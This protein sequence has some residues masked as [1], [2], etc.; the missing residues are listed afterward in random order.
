MLK[1]RCARRLTVGL[2]VLGLTLSSALS[3]QGATSRDSAG[4]Q[5]SSVDQSALGALPEWQVT[6]PLVNIGDANGPE[7]YEFH[8]AARPLRLSDGRIVVANDGTELRVYSAAGTFLTRLSRAGAGPGEYRNIQGLTRIAG[9]TLRLHDPSL[10][11]MD[12][13]APSGVV[14]R[15]EAGVRATALW[16]GTGKGMYFASEVPGTSYGRGVVQLRALLV[17]V[18]QSGLLQDTVAFLP[19]AWVNVVEPGHWLSVGLANDP[20][21]VAGAEHFAYAHG[22]LLE[23]RWFD[24]SGVIRAISRIASERTRVTASTIERFRRREAAREASANLLR[25]EPVPKVAPA[26]AEYLPQVSRLRLDSRDRAWICRADR[27][28]EP[29][30]DWVVLA[31]GGAPLARVRMPERFVP[32]DIG[33][34]YILGIATDEDGVQFVRMYGLL[35]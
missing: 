35:R 28:G 10:R 5:I 13:R 34:D 17:M 19:G 32:S 21:F 9:D 23:V 26:F 11:R 31:T 2:A 33:D 14:A 25:R 27:F 6:G 15:S 20:F 4:I 18:S 1:Q 16:S 22:D 8:R 7:E 29:S 12:V 30:T 3:A 24:H